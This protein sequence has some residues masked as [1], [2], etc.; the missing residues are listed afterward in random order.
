[1]ES[2][3]LFLA[4]FLAV[5]V[6]VGWGYVAEYFGFISPSQKEFLENKEFVSPQKVQDPTTSMQASTFVDS[7]LDA[8]HVVVDTPLYRAVFSSKGA[9]LVEF[10]LK[11]YSAVAGKPD[12]LQIFSEKSVEFAPL[13]LLIDSQPTWGQGIWSVSSDSLTLIGEEEGQITFT[14][15]VNGRKIIRLFSFVADK[16]LIKEDI[17]LHSQ[18]K[19]EVTLAYTMAASSFFGSSSYNVTKIAW[20][21]GSSLETLA[22]IQDL[23]IGF[24]RK[25]SLS[26][27]GITNNYFLLAIAPGNGAL[28]FKAKYESDIFRVS[29]TQNPVVL[30][31]EVSYSTSY[32]LGPKELDLLEAAPNNLDKSVHYGF[33]SFLSI[34]LVMFLEFIHSYIQNYGVAIILLTIFIKV[35]FWPLSQKSFSSMEK[36]KKIQPFVQEIREQYAD[37]KTEMNKRIMELYQTYKVNPMG[38]CLPILV[39]IPVFF[40]LY[41]AL[42]NSV[43]LRHAVFIEYIPF[44]HILWLTDLSVKD[45]FYIT[46]V[47]MG[48][49]MFIQ[50]L[51][52]PSMGDPL[53]RK[54]MLFMP[55]IFTV[56]FLGFPSGLVI[57]WLCSNII[58]IL[59]Q[60]LMIKK[61][62]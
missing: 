3:R 28:T 61:S 7:I 39:Q 44:T 53:Q 52:T 25:E 54:I 2:K 48:L 16:Y 46:P 1:M 18:I 43:S 55:I 27:A 6:V 41:E 49:S 35:L 38:G 10:S 22:D 15:V 42:L 30:D 60:W 29:L 31:S 34:P 4:V 23:S 47:L 13:G 24:E 40:A 57:Y 17:T 50:Q 19:E 21:E 36:M 45:P 58:S 37:D 59:Q 20:L 26:W 5:V 32:W 62:S 12:P 9:T 8:P 51:I 56:F 11:N 33:F 14:G